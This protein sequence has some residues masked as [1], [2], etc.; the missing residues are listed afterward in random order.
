[1]HQFKIF[2]I[3]I[4][5]AQSVIASEHSN[6]CTVTKTT[7]NDYEPN[8]FEKSN[9]LLKKSGQEIIVS[10]EKIVIY[11]RLLDQHCLPISDAKI[12][13]WQVDGHEKYL[14][15][16]LRNVAKNNFIKI[17]NTTSFT[18]NGTA[19]TNNKGEFVFIT[20]KPKNVHD[21]PSHIN[22]RA[23]HYIFKDIQTRLNISD[24]QIMD[25]EDNPSSNLIIKYAQDNNLEIYGYEI[26][27]PGFG[28]KKYLNDDM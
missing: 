1:M 28:Q 6:F 23:E 11:G 26:V 9:N 2:L 19:T 20:I 14:Y 4:F 24:N 21:L 10:G 22:I 17:D 12:Y 5:L 16:P 27:M 7:L 13:I 8:M 25:I 18:G 3:I 15:L